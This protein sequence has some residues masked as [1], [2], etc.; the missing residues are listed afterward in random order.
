MLGMKMFFI[1]VKKNN[2]QSKPSLDSVSTLGSIMS[3]MMNCPEI[4]TDWPKF[5]PSDQ[6]VVKEMQAS[7]RS[8]IWGTAAQ[9]AHFANQSLTTHDGEVLLNAL[10]LQSHTCSRVFF[11]NFEMPFFS[12]LCILILY[13]ATKANFHLPKRRIYFRQ[14]DL[15]NFKC[16]WNV[17]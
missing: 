5:R 2:P 13:P 15:F 12:F 14:S 8:I 4:M 6:W 16:S 17:V 3:I 9:V 7:L 11:R 1:W 10:L